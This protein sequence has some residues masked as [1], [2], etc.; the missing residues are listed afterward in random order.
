VVFLQSGSSWYNQT[1]TKEGP[2]PATQLVKRFVGLVDVMDVLQGPFS[3]YEVQYDEDTGETTVTFYGPS[4]P[5]KK[6]DKVGVCILLKQSNAQLRKEYWIS[7]DGG[8][9]ASLPTPGWMF[10]EDQRLVVTNAG[11]DPVEVWNFRRATVDEPLT[12]ADLSEEGL[13]Q[14]GVIL[15]RISFPH[16]TIL[17]SDEI[18]IS[19]GILPFGQWGLIVLGIL[20]AAALAIV[21]TRRFAAQGSHT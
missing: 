16:S 19:G 2:K 21:I 8:E 7:E 3:G 4:S 18:L 6:G 1:I 11:V 12:L 5:I 10:A 15:K 20:L 17:P 13:R 9:D 14:R